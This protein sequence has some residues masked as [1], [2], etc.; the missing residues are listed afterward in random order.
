[1]FGTSV[2]QEK[3][4]LCTARSPSPLSSAEL[5][6]GFRKGDITLRDREQY[7]SPSTTGYTQKV[8]SQFIYLF[9]HVVRYV[10]FFLFKLYNFETYFR[11]SCGQGYP[12]GGGGGEGTQRD[13]HMHSQ[14]GAAVTGMQ[15]A[16]R[17]KCSIFTASIAVLEFVS[18]CCCCCS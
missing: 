13:S 16:K 17:H 6:R 12:A 5:L 10:N 2:Y 3:G 4:T 9:Y 8:D 1:M 7:I 15:V 14:V 11:S 18:C